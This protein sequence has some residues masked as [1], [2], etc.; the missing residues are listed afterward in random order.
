VLAR[1]AGLLGFPG[2][3]VVTRNPGRQV[4]VA[5][6]TLQAQAVDQLDELPDAPAGGGWPEGLLADVRHLRLLVQEGHQPG[7]LLHRAVG[8]G[9]DGLVGAVG[10]ARGFGQHGDQPGDVLPGPA[11]PGGAQRVDLGLRV[12]GRL[13]QRGDEID[14]LLQRPVGHGRVHEVAHRVPVRPATG[15]SS[16][17][18]M[19]NGRAA[20]G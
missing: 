6:Q 5:V 8:G 10:V 17:D 9:P 4:A 16:W 1:P 13:L 18:R 11:H 7:H 2:L 14:E 12:V 20:G 3:V 15:L 19:A